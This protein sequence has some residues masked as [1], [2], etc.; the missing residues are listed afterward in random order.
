MCER[1]SGGGGGG[2]DEPTGGV[3][4]RRSKLNSRWVD[5][6]RNRPGL[7]I[8][9]VDE[10]ETHRSTNMVQKWFRII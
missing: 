8:K 10:T 6:A 4:Y 5:T 3:T 7:N 1:C 9:N 2:I